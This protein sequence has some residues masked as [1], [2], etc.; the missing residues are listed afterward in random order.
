MHR[1]PAAEVQGTQGVESAIPL[2]SQTQPWPVNPLHQFLCR[3]MEKTESLPKAQC[4]SLPAQHD[5]L[6]HHKC[7]LINYLQRVAS[8]V[9]AITKI[10]LT[11][12]DP[13]H[14]ARVCF[15]AIKLLQSCRVCLTFKTEIGT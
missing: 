7:E 9:D 4:L 8:Y 5:G 15:K 3:A 14:F 1:P 6:D 11:L 2:K 13:I 12:L 10:I